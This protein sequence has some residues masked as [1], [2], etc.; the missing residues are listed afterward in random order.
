MRE[1]SL[2]GTPHCAFEVYTEKRAGRLEVC[3]QCNLEK[4]CVD[5]VPRLNCLVG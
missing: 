3:V 5:Y 2:L 4:K 1:V